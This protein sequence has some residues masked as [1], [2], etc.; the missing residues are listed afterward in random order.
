MTGRIK[1]LKAGEPVSATD[2]PVIDYEYDMPDGFDAE[3][4]TFLLNEF[5]LPNPECPQ[6]FVCDADEVGGDY[7]KFASC[8]DAM[9]CHMMAGMTTGSSAKSEVALFIHQMIPHHQNAVNMAKAL[10]KTGTLQ[11]SDIE[12][13][14]DDCGMELILREIINTQNFQIQGMRAYADAMGYPAEDDCVVPIADDIHKKSHKGYKKKSKMKDEESKKES[15]KGKK[16]EEKS[17]VKGGKG[18]K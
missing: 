18:A 10:L 11:C 12:E 9:N 5:Q 16:K 2:E 4:G 8:I 13:E 15:K 14:T 3:C 17:S 7:A 1:L 6:Q